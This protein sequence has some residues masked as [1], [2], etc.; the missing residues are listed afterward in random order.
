[1][2]KTRLQEAEAALAAKAAEVEKAQAALDTEKASE[3]RV[4]DDLRVVEQK[5]LTTDPNDTRALAALASKRDALNLALEVWMRA[6]APA[7]EA[8]LAE[9]LKAQESAAR[10]RDAV[11]AA[12]E[13]ER[14]RAEAVRLEADLLERARAF[15]GE[16]G[17]VIGALAVARQGVRDLGEPWPPPGKHWP[18]AD[19]SDGVWFRAV[20]IAVAPPPPPDLEHERRERERVA[21]ERR[22]DER[23]LA[24]LTRREPEP[25]AR[26]AGLSEGELAALR[27][28]VDSPRSEVSWRDKQRGP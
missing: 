14:R 7:A 2:A 22:A 27:R 11:A 26:D 12:A 23:A 28:P 9:A 3:K 25:V 13:L 8:K 18:D 16:C 20:G 4:R 24:S 15:R 6:R 17:P 5:L 19:D 1:M 10:E 21:A